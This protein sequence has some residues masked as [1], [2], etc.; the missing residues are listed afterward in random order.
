MRVKELLEQAI[1]K[2]KENDIEEA[3][4]KARRILAY[5]LGTSKEYLISHDNDE[6]LKEY[7]IKYNKALQELLNGKPIQYI[8]GIQEFMGIEFIVN[9]D[10]LI[11]QP[12]TEILVEETI[13]TAK[14]FQNPQIL[15]LCTGSGAIG[16]TIAKELPNSRVTA[17]DISEKA[18]EVAKK[19]DKDN[20]VIF[21]QS[22]LFNNIYEKFDIIV[23]NPP[24]IK[25]AEINT[26]SKEVQNEPMLALDGGEDGLNFYRTIVENAHNYLNANGYLCL[27]IGDD[28]AKEVASLLEKN[29]NYVEIKHYKDLAGNDRVI[30]CKKNKKTFKI[31]DFLGNLWYS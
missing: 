31:L 27:E 14:E 6:I 9:E 5:V 18:L 1:T 28:Q 17:S 3:N 2:L 20:K 21:I 26:L 8:I 16:I 30:T 19:N 4:S 12:D 25:T 10:V 24:Y 22:D 15:D 29:S 23:S 11:P 7:E 13:K